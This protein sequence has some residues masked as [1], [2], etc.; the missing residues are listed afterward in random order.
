MLKAALVMIAGFAA[1]VGV[2]LGSATTF[3]GRS[4]PCSKYDVCTTTTT[5]TSS[6]STTTTAPATT[7]PAPTSTSPSPQ[8]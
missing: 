5:T 8:R 1:L 4:D 6:T 2:L 3:D 7:A